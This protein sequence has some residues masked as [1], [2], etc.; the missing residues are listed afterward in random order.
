M[1]YPILKFI[2]GIAF[3]LF[4]R[5]TVTG[6]DNVPA[7]GPVILVANHA[8]ILDPLVLG[9]A[10]KR[11]IVFMGK[12]ELFRIPVLRTLIR[13][14]GAFP[15]RRGQVDREAWMTAIATLEG[16]KVLG[17]FPEGTRTEDGSIGEAHSGAARLA[18][19]TGAVVVPVGIQGTYSALKKGTARLRRTKITVTIG[20]GMRFE[21]D[22]D[23][24]INKMVIEK[25]S[26]QIMESI[27]ALTASASESR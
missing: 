4:Y 22:P 24:R 14:L 9:V 27:K 8:S 16:G 1:L 3:K 7:E 25:A 13:A 20:R 15:V 12:A 10:L 11:R 23:G 2:L 19:R 6:L 26:T 5:I 21:P 18:L 17:I